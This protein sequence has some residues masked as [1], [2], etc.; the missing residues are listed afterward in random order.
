MGQ[1]QTAGELIA[2]SL[3]AQTTTRHFR[4]NL[5]LEQVRA[6][7]ARKYSSFVA[8][9][10]KRLNITP[11]LRNAVSVAAQWLV[12]GTTGG[13]KI[14]GT[15]GT[16]KTTLLRAMECVINEYAG[17]QSREN[18]YSLCSFAAS[19]IADKFRNNEAGCD[20][21][22]NFRLVAIDDLGVEPVVVKHYGNE[23]MPLV[24]IIH[25]RAN[26][27]KMTIIVTNIDKDSI[28]ERYGPRV[29]DRMRDMTTILLNG[30]SNRGGCNG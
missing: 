24:D 9:S 30:D 6:G 8:L 17:R 12:N 20:N 16:G 29:Y 28:L 11:E 18:M 27:N 5:P 21:F 2:G 1:T 10:G 14:M 13:L 3:S 23:I 26:D 22:Y 4:I 25:R 7:I 19:E 15:C